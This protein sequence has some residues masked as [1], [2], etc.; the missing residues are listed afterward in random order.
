MKMKKRNRKVQRSGFPY[1]QVEI[2]RSQLSE[3]CVDSI[4]L[5]LENS[6]LYV[7]HAIYDHN[8]KVFKLGSAG[9]GLVTQPIDSELR[10]T[11][12]ATARQ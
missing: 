1:I 10:D 9:F 4:Y 6:N 5:S 8:L 7:W 2:Y 11:N 12:N 3:D